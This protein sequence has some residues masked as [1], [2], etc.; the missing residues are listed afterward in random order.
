MKISFLTIVCLLIFYS[1]TE[2][3]ESEDEEKIISTTDSFAT[4]FFNYNLKEAMPFCTPE[5]EKWIRY[6]ASNIFQE[7]IDVLRNQDEGATHKTDDITY[8]NDTS[9]IVKCHVYN[10]MKTD[11]IG[12]P[13]RI[14]EHEI[15]NINLVKRDDK[16]LVKMEGPLQ[17]EKQN[18]D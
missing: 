9:A 3:Y 5:S 11:T 2:H 15:Y 18:R 1:C 12:K 13:G 16:W 4:H 10:V 7:D 6:K 17:S 14:S 8:V